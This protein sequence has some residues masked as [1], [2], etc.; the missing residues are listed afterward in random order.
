MIAGNRPI[1]YLRISITD[2]CNF[3]CLYCI[4]ASPFK[5]IGHDQIARYEEII[6]ITQLACE[7]G[8]TKVRITGGEPF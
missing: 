8:I 7:M 1:N 4:P 2:R 3:R 6:R 5:V